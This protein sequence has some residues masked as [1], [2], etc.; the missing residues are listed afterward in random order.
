MDDIGSGLFRAI[1]L[2]LALSSSMAVAVSV[3]HRVDP[4]HTK[5]HHLEVDKACRMNTT[6][7][8]CFQLCVDEEV[9]TERYKASEKQKQHTD[10]I[11]D[12]IISR[13]MAKQNPYG[14][15]VKCLTSPFVEVCKGA[16]TP[17]FHDTVY[18]C[19]LT[20]DCVDPTKCDVDNPDCVDGSQQ[21]KN[22]VQPDCQLL[23]GANS[24]P[25]KECFLN[26]YIVNDSIA[27]PIC[28]RKYSSRGKCKNTFE[29]DCW[30]NPDVKTMEDLYECFEVKRTEEDITAL[31]TTTACDREECDEL[32]PPYLRTKHCEEMCD[33]IDE[34]RG[35]SPF[36]ECIDDCD[37]ISYPMCKE[38]CQ[39][40]LKCVE[41]CEKEANGTSPG[42]NTTAATL[43]CLAG[44]EGRY[45]ELHPDPNGD[46]IMTRKEMAAVFC[47]D[48][49]DIQLIKDYV[50]DSKVRAAVFPSTGTG[51]SPTEPS[52]FHWL[53]NRRTPEECR[54]ACEKLAEDKGVA[55]G[56]CIKDSCREPLSNDTKGALCEL[57]PLRVKTLVLY[58]AAAAEPKSLAWS[59]IDGL[60]NSTIFDGYVYDSADVGRNN[61]FYETFLTVKKG[62]D[63]DKHCEE[64]PDPSTPNGTWK[65]NANCDFGCFMK[66]REQCRYEPHKA[67]SLVAF[68]SCQWV[69]DLS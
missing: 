69:V 18:P 42:G 8:E 38:G 60:Y 19:A 2:T 53:L 24:A 20:E 64:N 56:E 34:M 50:K 28:D 63:C 59:D 9:V 46:G 3:S 25:C 17:P 61:K 51:T 32:I 66:H 6:I 15:L 4:R 30:G 54:T 49:N 57:D 10:N 7:V 65:Y 22:P 55:F 31:V 41:E 33:A 12:F 52:P 16:C 27:L 35:K 67:I 21:C 13:K 11:T 47:K 43:N 45:R 40:R 14:C 68:S 44:C 1:L 5:Q 36:L 29:D 26:N 37:Y 62:V 23:R 48:N 58:A 39:T